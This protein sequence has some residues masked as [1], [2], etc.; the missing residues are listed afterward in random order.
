MVT[1]THF[2]L[3]TKQYG[4]MDIR[5]FLRNADVYHKSTSN[6]LLLLVSTSV[7]VLPLLGSEEVLNE[8]LAGTNV[9]PSVA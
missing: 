1:R 3:F 9:L 4:F 7:N 6:S 8:C 5:C 2:I